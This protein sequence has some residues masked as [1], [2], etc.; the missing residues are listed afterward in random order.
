[1]RKQVLSLHSKH[2]FMP[3]PVRDLAPIYSYIRSSVRNGYLREELRRQLMAFENK[4]NFSAIMRSLVPGAL[5]I[6]D[7]D[8]I[9]LLILKDDIGFRGI[10]IVGGFFELKSRRKKFTGEVKVNGWQFKILE[11]LSKSL[12]MDLWYFINGGYKEFYLFNVKRVS[13][14]FRVEGEG[15]ARD[16]YAVIEKDEVIVMEP[17]EVIPTFRQLFLEGVVV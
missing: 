6:Y 17:H 5:A 3:K 14:E 11:L 12:D 16:L 2:F 4:L 13:P 8:A 9:P 7:L 1:M 10:R 15:P